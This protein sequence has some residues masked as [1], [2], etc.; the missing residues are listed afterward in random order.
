MLNNIPLPPP[1]G[2]KG[3]SLSG[4][5]NKVGGGRKALVSGEGRPNGEGPYGECSGIIKT[6]YL[7]SYFQ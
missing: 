3:E 2:S 4:P 5:S 1:P 7:N 6:A